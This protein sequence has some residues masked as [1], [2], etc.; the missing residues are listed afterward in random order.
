MPEDIRRISIPAG[1]DN[2]VTVQPPTNAY[3]LFNVNVAPSK[4]E[5][6][7]PEGVIMEFTASI[8]SFGFISLTGGFPVPVKYGWTVKI[9]GHATSNLNGVVVFYW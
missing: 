7:T 8:I 6:I 1:T 3:V 5:F 9:Y 4:I 2:F